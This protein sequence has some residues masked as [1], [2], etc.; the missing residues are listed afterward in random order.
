MTRSVNYCN[1]KYTAYHEYVVPRSIP[2]TGSGPSPG[3]AAEA[4]RASRGNRIIG[5]IC[6]IGALLFWFS[7]V[8]LVKM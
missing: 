8:K 6:I 2:M 4:A 1:K 3:V 7:I 5:P